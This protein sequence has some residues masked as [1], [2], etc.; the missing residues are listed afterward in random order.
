[1]Y[2]PK[3]LSFLISR[4][5]TL[6][7]LKKLFSDGT[8]SIIFYSICLKIS[9]FWDIKRPWC[10]NLENSE[11]SMA[12]QENVKLQHNLQTILNY[13]L[14]SFSANSRPIIGD[15]GTIIGDTR[16]IISITWPEI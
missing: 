16:P 12:L 5:K 2:N 13:I 8:A 1:M 6:K 10:G 14:N 3:K 7:P 15:T 4:P 11:D 9:Y